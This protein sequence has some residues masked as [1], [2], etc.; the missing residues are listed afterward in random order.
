MSRYDA[1]YRHVRNTVTAILCAQLDGKATTAVMHDERTLSRIADLASAVD[2]LIDFGTE[3][4][5][6]IADLEASGIPFDD[7][8]VSELLE[9]RNAEFPL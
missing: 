3:Y 7:G 8:D 1:I 9:S 2:A 6:A 4:S 5:N